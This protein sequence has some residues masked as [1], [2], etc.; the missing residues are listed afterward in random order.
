MRK[1][2]GN[3]APTPTAVAMLRNVDRIAR[4]IFLRSNVSGGILSSTRGEKLRK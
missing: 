3:T 1:V 4:R 2:S